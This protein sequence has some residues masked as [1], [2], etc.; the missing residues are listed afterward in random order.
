MSYS[1]LSVHN[2]YE[3]YYSRHS[4][5]TC[6]FTNRQHRQ[7][8]MIVSLRVRGTNHSI[9]I[10]YP[11]K[12]VND[13]RDS[14]QLDITDSGIEWILFVACERESHRLL[15]IIITIIIRFWKNS[16]VTLITF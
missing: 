9:I 6:Y 4:H 1:S 14:S 11:T 16:I 10:Y 12:T 2:K 15:A 3:L 5:P 13:A 8:I 7:I